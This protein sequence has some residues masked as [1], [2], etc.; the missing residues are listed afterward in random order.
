MTSA[1]HAAQS[2][3]G[4][5]SADEVRRFG[6]MADQWWDPHGQFRPL[7]ALNPTRLAF[8]RDAAC[9]HFG[10]D[11]AGGAPLAGLACVDI[12]CGGGLISEPVARLG[13]DVTGIDATAT[14]IEVAK[15]HAAQEGLDIDYRWVLPE[16]LAGW[17]AR[18]DLVLALEV[19]E[20]VADL[21]AFFAAACGVLEPGGL[22]VCATLN[23]TFKS[24]ALAKV[25]AEYVL[26][27]LPPGTHD[28]RKFVRPAEMAR[29]MRAHGLIVSDARGLSFDPVRQRWRLSSDLDVNYIAAAHKPGA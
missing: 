2:G 19:I 9:R 6:A 28:W 26:R 16:E 4:T 7:H 13:A 17:D 20:H 5:A 11:A 15:V 23:R 10:R 18:Y 14:A 1:S 12:G 8:I 22:M 25:G 21:D 29:R 24:L 3:S 27:W